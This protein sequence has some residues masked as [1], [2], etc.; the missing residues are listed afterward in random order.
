MKRIGLRIIFV[1]VIAAVLGAAL[2]Y[3]SQSVQNA[4]EE[5]SQLERA[6]LAEKEALD[7]LTA[8]WEYLNSPQRL[9]RLAQEYFGMQT[10]KGE[11]LLKED[12]SLPFP[13]PIENT[14]DNLM[15]RVSHETKADEGRGL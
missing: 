12:A 7:I 2:L 14:P 6:I 15:Q 1:W 5:L 10:P 3:T 13:A 9:E 8:E 4:G 11:N